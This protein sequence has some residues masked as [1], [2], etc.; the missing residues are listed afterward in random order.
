MQMEIQSMTR[1]LS[2]VKIS[3][4]E[5]KGTG[6]LILF[7]CITSYDKQLLKE[8]LFLFYKHGKI[9]PRK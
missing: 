8:G 7:K 1:I 2:M 6:F 5:R 9:G 4:E 3:Q